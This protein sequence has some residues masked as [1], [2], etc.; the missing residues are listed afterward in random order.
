MAA[1]TRP[2]STASKKTGKSATKAA[3]ST[4]ATAARGTSRTAGRPA[5]HHRKLKGPSKSLSKRAGSLTAAAEILTS[6]KRVSATRTSPT[7][8]W[9]HA[10]IGYGRSVPELS[11]AK[12]WVGNAHSRIFLKLGKRRPDG[13]C[14]EAFDGEEPVE[15]IDANVAAIGAE[16][17]AGIRTPNGGQAEFL[18]AYGEKM[19]EV[20]ELY[21]LPWD[22]TG[23]LA[24]RVLSVEELQKEGGGWGIFEGPGLD[25]IPVP[26]GVQPIRI[27]RPDDVFDALAT[28]STRA[29]IEILEELQILTRL[30]RSSSISRLALAGVLLLAAE[31]DTELDDAGGPDDSEIESPLIVDMILNGAKAIDDPASAASWMPYILTVPNGIEIDKAAKLIEF[32]ADDA[33]QAVNRK[34]AVQRLAQGLDVPVEIVLG[35]QSTTFANAAQISEDSYQ[36][37]IGP[38]MEFLCAGLTQ[39]VLWPTIAARMG[40]SE[41]QIEADGYPQEILDVGVMHDA[42][43]LVS[44][45]DRTKDVIAAYRADTTQTAVSNQDLRLAVGLDADGGPTPEETAI[46]VDSIRLQ[47][48]RENILAPASD[49]A[50]SLDDAATKAVIPGESEG[51]KLIGQASTAGA[52]A[53][54]ISAAADFMLERSAERTGSTI[55]NRAKGDVLTTLSGVSNGDVTRTIGPTHADKLLNG[56][57]PWRGDLATFESMVAEWVQD[58]GIAGS[59][60]IAKQLGLVAEQAIVERLYGAARPTLDPGALSTLLLTPA[61]P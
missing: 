5:T 41:E 31:L 8:T 16:V 3:K 17:V 22:T 27:W 14:D 38:S 33:V 49:A 55:R 15:G 50:V 7:K 12:M 21:V 19:F 23:G 25:K 18:R 29:C 36:L 51:S 57:E 53:L 42:S 4:R 40:I 39:S 1:M 35:H 58:A 6:E 48:I 46:R 52:L 9:Q 45:P 43:R 28:A 47:K 30:V 44:R 37:H 60:F 54:R 10:V 2:A 34:E 20:G 13:S 24:Y 26:D 32:K 11:A 59:G 56:S 61:G